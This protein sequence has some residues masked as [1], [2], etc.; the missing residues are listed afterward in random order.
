MKPVCCKLCPRNTNPTKTVLQKRGFKSLRNIIYSHPALENHK[1]GSLPRPWEVKR[2]AWPRVSQ[3]HFLRVVL[4]IYGI[5]LLLWAQ[6]CWRRHHSALGWG[7]PLIKVASL[8]L[9]E[10]PRPHR[11]PHRGSGRTL[12]KADVNHFQVSSSSNMLFLKFMPIWSPLERIPRECGTLD[13]QIC[14]L[15]LLIYSMNSSWIPAMCWE[16]ALEIQE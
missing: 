3:M 9:A 4:G 6:W 16:E 14:W 1:A 5:S 2:S 11:Y 13:R 8:P 7:S 12:K 10:S 15:N